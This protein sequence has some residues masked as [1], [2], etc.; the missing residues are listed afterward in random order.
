MTAAAPQTTPA[1]DDGA[2]QQIQETKSTTL[3]FLTPE[4]ASY[5][6]G[7]LFYSSSGVNLLKRCQ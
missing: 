7:V 4:V 5:F 2:R 6:V 3:T 1:G